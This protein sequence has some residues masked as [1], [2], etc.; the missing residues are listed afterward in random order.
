[1]FLSSQPN[2]TVLLILL[3]A[4]E[5]AGEATAPGE[6]WL[7]VDHQQA[8]CDSENEERYAGE[9]AQVSQGA[10]EALGEGVLHPPVDCPLQPV[11]DPVV[12]L[13]DDV[14]AFRLLRLAQELIASVSPLESMGSCPTGLMKFS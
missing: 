4:G 8:P 14:L 7:V 11:D 6:G 13:R 12:E 1:M 2:G 5:G 9:H 3:D 10:D